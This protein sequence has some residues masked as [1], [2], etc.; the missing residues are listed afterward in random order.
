MVTT[1]RGKGG[2]IN[3]DYSFNMRFTTPGIT[4]FSPD[5]GQY[6]TMRLEANKEEETPNWWAWVSEENMLRM[7]RNEAGIYPT[8]Y[9]GEIFLAN[10]SRT[11]ELFANR[12]SY[13]HNLSVSGSTE[14]SDYRISLAYADNQANLTTAYD[15]QK[16]LNFRLNYGLQ[17]TDWLRFESIASVIRTDTDSPSIGLD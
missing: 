12:N 15:G 11:D 2:K 14:K 6:A 7:Q 4:A 13:Q 10:S 8:Q 5:M 17:M 16:Q 1:K 9:Y 3:V